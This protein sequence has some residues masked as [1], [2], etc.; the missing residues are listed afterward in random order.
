MTA[1][2]GRAALAATLPRRRAPREGSVRTLG[3][4]EGAAEEAEAAAEWYGR[5]LGWPTAVGSGGALELLTGVRIDVVDVPLGA[6][7][8]MLRRLREGGTGPVAADGRRMRFVVAPGSAE[9]LPGLLQ[10]LEWGGIALDLRAH[11]A[12]GAVPAPV[13]PE[14]AAPWEAAD[15]TLPVWVRPPLPGCDDTLPAAGLPE[16]RGAGSPD[17]ARLVAVAATECHRARLFPRA[18]RFPDLPQLR[19]T[20][21]IPRGRT[22]YQACALS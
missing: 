11:G 5:R 10:W 21:R 19:Q 1:P 8:R 14:G 4:T 20:G 9:E 6:G 17:L 2:A 16:L 3:T 7:L 22:E 18:P 12:G 13:G 15:R